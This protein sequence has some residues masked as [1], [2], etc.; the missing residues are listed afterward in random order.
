MSTSDAPPAAP[1]PAEP[2]PSE[3]LSLPAA[4]RD[5][6]RLFALLGMVVVWM[7]PNWVQVDVGG[8]ARF[9]KGAVRTGVAGAL[10]L[11]ALWGLA[12]SSLAARSFRGLRVGVALTDAAM[13]L[14]VGLLLLTDHPWIPGGDLREAW[15]PVFLPLAMLA[16]LDAVV[17]GLRSTTASQVTFIRGGAALFA[18]VALMAEGSWIPAGIAFWLGVTSF[19]FVRTSNAPAARRALEVLMLAAGAL[20]G[21]APWIQRDL[22]GSHETIGPELTWPVYV[23]CVLAALVV[24]TALD[25]VMRPEAEDTPAGAR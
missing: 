25:G 10:S 19:V 6:L 20:A 8:V 13:A 21:L 11:I 18:A 3:A 1:L 17:H 14:L 7:L 2:R 15:I 16:L 12:S 4:G 22:V 9:E 5:R 24:T 23:W